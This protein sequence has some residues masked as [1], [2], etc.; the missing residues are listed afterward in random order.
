MARLDSA[1]AR[2][3]S[4]LA[5]LRETSE[6]R[7]FFSE[8][9]IGRNGEL[10][11]AFKYDA[12]VKA[13]LVEAVKLKATPSTALYRGLFVQANSAF[14]AYVRDLSSIAADHVIKRVEKY[15]ELPESFRLQHIYSSSQVLQHMKAGTI[16]GQKFDFSGLTK[17]LGQC[18]SDSTEF[19]I[20]PEVFTVMIGNITPDRLEALFDKIGLPEPFNPGVGRNGSIRKVLG[21]TRHGSAAKLAKERLH[22]VIG[23]RN[24]LVHGD[25]SVAIEQSDFDGTIEFLEAMID[26]LDEIVKPIIS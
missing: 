3:L 12:A 17:A 15:S 19:S 16:S 8:I 26:A 14:E 4:Y 10:M 11:G 21:E 20:M 2:A 7:Q 6:V 23:L 9:V 18:F 22:E 5:E 25:L 1:K 24:T 13:R